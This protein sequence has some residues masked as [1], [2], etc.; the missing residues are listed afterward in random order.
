VQATRPPPP[1]PPPPPPS[2]LAAI[3]VVGTR[4]LPI[5]IPFPAISAASA[6]VGVGVFGVLW[7]TTMGYAACEDT[8]TCNSPTTMAAEQETLTGEEQEAVRN[9]EAGKPYDKKAFNRARQKQ[10]KNEKYAG[11]RNRDKQRGGG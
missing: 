11:Q 9:K 5:R 4:P 7:P 6:T 1:P 3:T 2:S 10:I 8:G